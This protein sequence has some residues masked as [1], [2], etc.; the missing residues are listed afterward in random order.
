LA[1]LNIGGSGVGGFEY[2]AILNIGGSGV[3]GFEIW[4]F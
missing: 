1:V 2:L 4:R 3:G